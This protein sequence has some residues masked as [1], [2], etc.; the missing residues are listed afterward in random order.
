M[1]AHLRLVNDEVNF[2]TLKKFNLIYLA[3]PYTL[4]AK[5][6]S[7]AFE[8]VTALAG[9]LVNSGLN[10]I[11]AITMG[12]PLSVYGGVSVNDL[13]IWYRLNDA[14]LRKCEDRKSVV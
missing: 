3:S 7:A 5:G 11:P 8:D 14:V 9:K 6:L 13:S 12:H 2:D 10:I 1:P 4:Y